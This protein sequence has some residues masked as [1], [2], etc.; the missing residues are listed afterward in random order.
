MEFLG[1]SISFPYAV[2]VAVC[3]YVVVQFLQDR[4]LREI[5]VVGYSF[6]IL[7]WITGAQFIFN[8]RALIQEG[9]EKYQSAGLFRIAVHDGWL[10]VVT[11]PQLV[12]QVCRAPEDT[13]LFEKAIQQTLQVDYTLGVESVTVPYHVDVARNALTR[14]LNARFDDIW[15]EIQAAFREEIG[16]GDAWKEIPAVTKIQRIVSR[17][18]N[19]LFVNL[20]LCRDRDWM[21]LNI[22]YTI[23]VAQGASALK[24]TPAP[25]KPLISW[26]LTKLRAQRRLANKLV[27][28]VIRERLHDFNEGS[29]KWE[30]RPNDLISW[31]I[32]GCPPELRTVSSLTDR[33]LTVNFAAI[34]TSS[35]T[36]SNAVYRLA[37]NPE[38]A[39]PMREEVER[40]VA[41][42]GWSKLSLS[43]MHRVDSFIR[44]TQR[45]QA[46]SLLSLQRWT[47]KP[48]TFSN[49]VKVPAGYQITSASEML[50]HDPAHHGE[51]A[52]TF[53]PWRWATIRENESQAL[54]HQMVATAPTLL[55]FGHGKH[56]CPGRFFAANELKAM[57]AHLVLEYDV[58]FK[59]GE[60]RLPSMEIEHNILPPQMHI[61]IRK[62]QKTG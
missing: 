20:P 41:T 3:L 9:Y 44:E 51:H 33:L 43:K 60:S 50:Q 34:H 56:A 15:D 28:S 57:L 10:I 55:H 45:V 36:F 18:S 58:R 54:K 32:E 5:P 8:A 39:E 24:V 59:A 37:D 1:F 35:I 16:A 12:D 42:D 29:E 14:N 6:P 19:R 52:A 13:L 40:V 17:V 49:G 61:E 62:R 38:W 48:F 23:D 30:D 27:G 47:M 4:R 31:L 11:S 7:N 26:L 2:A 25:F 22:D 53:D 46:I 21:Q